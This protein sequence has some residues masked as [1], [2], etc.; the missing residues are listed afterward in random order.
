[1]FSNNNQ[2]S[3]MISRKTLGVPKLEVIKAAL[4]AKETG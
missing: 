2:G 4:E 1:M 3:L